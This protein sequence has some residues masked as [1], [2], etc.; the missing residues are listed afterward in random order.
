VWCAGGRRGSDGSKASAKI[1]DEGAA[2]IDGEIQWPARNDGRARGNMAFNTR[3]R[4]HTHTHTHTHMHTDED[5]DASLV[6]KYKEVWGAA[7][8]GRI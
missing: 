1:A 3:A 4:A 8:P 7:A 2:I 6:A 5:D